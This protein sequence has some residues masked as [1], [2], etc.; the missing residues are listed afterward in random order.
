M[1]PDNDAISKAES[2]CPMRAGQAPMEHMDAIARGRLLRAS[3]VQRDLP[4]DAPMAVILE[5]I[6]SFLARPHPDVG[7]PGP[8]CPF[9][10]TALALDTIWL[11][12]IEDR[13]PD[14]ASIVELIGQYRDLFL[15][16]EPRTGPMAIN[17]TILVVFPNLGGDAAKMIDD[18]QSELKASFV[19]VGLM[20][21][22]FH[23]ENESPGL[24]NPEFRPLR[25]PVPMLAIRHMVE[26]DLPFLRRSIDAPSVRASYLRSYLRRL[27]STLRVKYLDQAVT[28]LAEAIHA[29]A[30]H[31]TAAAPKAT[32]RNNER[33]TD[34][35]AE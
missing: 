1:N 16:I 9:T 3:D 30:K 31:K 7:R 23:A 18:A 33:V 20:L 19:D 34:D 14:L 27:G 13:D 12:E 11:T 26:S 28:S 6:N 15:D 32:H 22:E 4:A 17:K 10:P 24:R 29:S 35:T 5:W 21:G 25:S 2:K 8:V